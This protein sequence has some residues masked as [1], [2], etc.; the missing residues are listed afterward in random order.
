VDVRNA[1]I[2]TYVLISG[3]MKD[4]VADEVTYGFTD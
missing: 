3:V 1:W 2:K 4:A